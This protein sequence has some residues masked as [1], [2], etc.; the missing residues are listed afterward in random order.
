[1]PGR[2]EARIGQFR[3]GDIS[4]CHAL[5]QRDRP[6]PG[7]APALAKSRGVV[8]GEAVDRL[9]KLFAGH[10][11]EVAPGATVTHFRGVIRIIND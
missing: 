6:L 11:P 8:A 3:K 1:M 7:T 4:V 2:F 5:N 9:V 10:V